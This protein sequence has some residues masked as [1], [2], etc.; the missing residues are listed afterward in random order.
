MYMVLI[1]I[2]SLS[3]DVTR[4]FWFLLDSPPLATLLDTLYNEVS[5][6]VSGCNSRTP[7]KLLFLRSTLLIGT[8]LD[9]FHDNWGY[10]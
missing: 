6:E 8:S 4:T 7:I 2:D 5:G 9:I 3:I 10:L 1:I